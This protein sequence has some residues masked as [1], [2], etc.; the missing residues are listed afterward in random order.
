[1]IMKPEILVIRDFDVFS[2]ILIENGF[3]VI[4]F[5]AIKT[6]TI[7]D[8][9]ELDETISDL[10]NYDGIFITSPNAAA[11]FLERLNKNYH[12]KIY[13]LGKRINELFNSFGFETIF[14]ENVKNAEELINSIPKSEIQ[15]KSF[16]YLRGNRSLRV[17]PEKLKDLA[18]VRELIIYKTLATNP[19]G[20]QSQEITQKLKNGQI[21]VICFFSPSGAEVFLETFSD[22]EQGE[23]KIAAIGITTAGFLN[24]KNLRVDFIAEKP[25]A[26]DFAKGLIDYLK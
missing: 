25:N 1:M 9:S 3:P 5:P 6:E 20:K 19:N 24:E 7:S 18:Q 16:L 17:I 10:E 22:F 12:G 13:V 23:I 2:Q 11:P 14:D 8:F 4:N 15:D 26:E 21:S